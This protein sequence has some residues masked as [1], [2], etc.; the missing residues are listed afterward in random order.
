MRKIQLDSSTGSDYHRL[1][2]P[3]RDTDGCLKVRGRGRQLK[4]ERPT[5][6]GYS[7]EQ[8]RDEP[9]GD[10]FD[11]AENDVDAGQR[12]KISHF[13]DRSRRRLRKTFG[14]IRRDRPCMFVSM[15]YHETNPHPKKAKRDLDAFLKRLRRRYENVK[16]SAVWRMEF[17]KRGV[18]HFHLLI[19]GIKWINAQIA[20]RI[21]WEVT[22]ETS[23]A[24]RKSGVDVERVDDE[25]GK[26]ANYCTEYLEIEAN[27]ERCE[28][29]DPGRFW[30][31]WER[32]NLPVADWT[33]A[34]TLTAAEAYW[35]I[36]TLVDEWGVD[37]PDG[38]VPPSLTINTRGDPRPRMD[39]LLKR[40]TE[41]CPQ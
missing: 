28:W 40:V 19:W 30:G 25:P 39:R 11:P 41:E 24:H 6:R 35:L 22:D 10:G 20:S 37:L 12:E 4:I 7:T 5:G 15:T 17:Q 1:H 29:D 9:S 21:W 38:V 34:R 26:A 36:E 31:V 16:V 18:V 27:P 32:R 2:G 33:S 8:I 3:N 14:S 13:S 23:E